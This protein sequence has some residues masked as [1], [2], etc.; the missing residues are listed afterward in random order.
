[1]LVVYGPIKLRVDRLLMVTVGGRR[2]GST[3]HLT[4]ARPGSRMVSSSAA[5]NL[6]LL[7]IRG[8]ILTDCLLYDGRLADGAQQAGGVAG[9][10]F[11]QAIRYPST[12][13]HP[14]LPVDFL[15]LF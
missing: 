7:V 6:P 10:T 8:H 4:M 13:L 11:L 1:M 9:A 15:C 14:Q 12:T 5:S 2:L 3:S